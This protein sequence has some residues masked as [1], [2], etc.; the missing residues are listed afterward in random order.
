M[1][2]VKPVGRLFVE[3]LLVECCKAV[4]IAGDFVPDSGDLV[5]IRSDLNHISAL[6]SVRYP[7]NVIRNNNN[8]VPYALRFDFLQSACQNAC[9]CLLWCKSRVRNC[10]N[11]I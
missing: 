1:L 6:K 5:E 2:A 7:E 9:A 3:H 4:D 8:T 10:N 11:W